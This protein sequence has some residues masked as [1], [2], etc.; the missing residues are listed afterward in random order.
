MT[1]EEIF[2][3]GRSEWGNRPQVKWLFDFF[4]LYQ[5]AVIWPKGLPPIVNPDW[6]E[7]SCQ[8][9]FYKF[10]EEKMRD[11]GIDLDNTE[12]RLIAKH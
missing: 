8:Y 9:S 11:L 12:Q 3:Y 2:M 7:N 10:Y 5:K 1:E 4:W 6:E